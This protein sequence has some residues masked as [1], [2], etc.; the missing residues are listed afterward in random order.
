MRKLEGDDHI[1]GFEKKDLPKN[2]FGIL[3][4]F[5]LKGNRLKKIEWL[6]RIIPGQKN[7]AELI[8]HFLHVINGDVRAT[9][10]KCL[11]Y[12]KSVTILTMDFEFMGAGVP[13]RLFEDQLIEALEMKKIYGKEKVK[14][15]MCLDPRRP[16]LLQLVHRYYNYIDGYK[17]YSPLGY[18]AND[19]VIRMILYVLPKPVI[20][21][22]TNTSPVFGKQLKNP[23]Y[24]KNLAHPCYLYELAEEF[25]KINF[26]ADHWGG[27]DENWKKFIDDRLGGNFF[28]NV[29]FTYMKPVLS[30][31]EK[32]ENVK[33][34]SDYCMGEIEEPVENIYEAY[35]K[36]PLHIKE[37]LNKSYLKFYENQ[38]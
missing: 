5:L 3:S 38:C 23:E 18:K 32:H 20:S 29:A 31:L 26:S 33:F 37:K 16:N 24:Y 13:E 2:I 11:Q 10:D 8:S 28:T 36:L 15:F 7:L 27:E 9:V 4:R 17:L 19:T 25:P 34:G 22:C 21:H 12:C 1:H 6:L 30:E 14:V 35:M